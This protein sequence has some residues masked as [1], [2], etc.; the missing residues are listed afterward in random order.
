[1]LAVAAVG[2]VGWAF[3]VTVVADEIQLVSG[4]LRTK[5]ICEPA[6]T[7]ENVADNW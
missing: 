1:M 6:A 5:I 2:A 4:V 7:P 3:I